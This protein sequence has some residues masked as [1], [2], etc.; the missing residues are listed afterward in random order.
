MDRTR[1]AT[2][3]MMAR[4]PCAYAS[5]M[6]FVEA[7]RIF[8]GLFCNGRGKKRNVSHSS[9]EHPMC[10]KW[11]AFPARK[12]LRILRNLKRLTQQ[13]QQSLTCTSPVHDAHG[14]GGGFRSSGTKD[15]GRSAR[16]ARVR[17]RGYRVSYGAGHGD[18]GCCSSSSASL[19]SPPL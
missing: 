6:C 15:R 19:R 11:F 9:G 3:F 12:K 16:D 2:N 13:T 7:T 8:L 17:D 10:F 18:A 1:V 14:P 4:S 5:M